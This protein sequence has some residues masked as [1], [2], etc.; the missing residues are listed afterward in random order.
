MIIRAI[1]LIIFSM[2]LLFVSTQVTMASQLN[3]ESNMVEKLAV[4]VD[5]A[6]FNRS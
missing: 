1:L 5:K 4:L 6:E 2:P 3:T